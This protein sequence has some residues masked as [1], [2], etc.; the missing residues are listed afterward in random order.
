[1]DAYH[2]DVKKKG[3]KIETELE[4]YEYGMRDFNIED[5]DGNILTFGQEK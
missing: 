4:S 5:P 1:V 3:A 2:A